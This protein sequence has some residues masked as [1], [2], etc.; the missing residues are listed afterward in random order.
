MTK[1]RRKRAQSKKDREV[2]LEL[3]KKYRQGKVNK[4]V[5]FDDVAALLDGPYSLFHSKPMTDALK[6]P[7]VE[8]KGP[9]SV[10]PYNNEYKVYVETL[11]LGANRIPGEV[12]DGYQILDFLLQDEYSDVGIISPAYHGFTTPE[13]KRRTAKGFG[14]HKKQFKR[15]IGVLNTGFHWAA[16]YIDKENKECFMFDPLQEEANYKTI[17]KSMTGIIEG[18]LEMEG[19]LE[20]NE[21][22]G[23][24][25]RDASS[26][27]VEILLSDE[28]W[29]DCMY[30]L[31]P[32]LRIGFLYKA[33]AFIGKTEAI[34]S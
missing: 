34:Q 25:Q 4:I 14:A 10:R 1:A 7:S 26:C 13:Q 11:N 29:G 32:Y 6:L 22:S 8:V 23:C 31:L 27:G 28:T 18:V 12:V 20:Y 5:H 15:V 24:K 16:F 3:A 19:L 30:N 2:A 17:K 9:V 33:I 21:L